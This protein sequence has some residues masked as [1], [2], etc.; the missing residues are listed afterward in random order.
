M[1]GKTVSRRLIHIPAEN[2]G[3]LPNQ[4]SYTALGKPSPQKKAAKEKARSARGLSNGDE[5]LDPSRFW[6]EGLRLEDNNFIPGTEL[7][8]T[9]IPEMMFAVIEAVK[10]GQGTNTVSSR[11]KVG[12]VE[13]RVPII[14]INSIDMTKTFRGAEL[15]RVMYYKNKLLV[16]AHTNEM[17]KITAIED[18]KINSMGRKLSM[19]VIGAGGGI[20]CSAMKYGLDA[21]GMN[22][23]LSWMIDI[24]GRYLQNAIDNCD[25]VTDKTMIVH[26]DASHVESNLLTPMN[27]FLISNACTGASTAGRAKN[28]LS[29]PEAHETGGLM[30]LKTIDILERFLPPVV[31][32]ENVVAYNSTASADLLSGKLKSL[33]YKIQVATYGGEMGTLEDRKRSIMLATHQDVDMDLRTLVAIME[34]EA[35]IK[36]VLDDVPLDSDEWNAYDYLVKKNERDIA[37]GKGFRFEG[38]TGEETKCGTLTA[39]RH[40]VR[41]TDVFIAH[42]QNGQPGRVDLFRMPSVTEQARLMKIPK[43]LVAGR[44]KSTAMEIMGQSG[45]FALVSAIGVMVGR[46]L[47]RQF[48]NIPFDLADQVNLSET[49]YEFVSYDEPTSFEDE[50][51]KFEAE[52]TKVGQTISMF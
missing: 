10:E 42:P 17:N 31:I 41:S 5:V 3:I 24:E 40:K 16:Q 7:K 37:D 38:L 15:V 51:S 20:F 39:G 48:N 50:E 8:I 34:K 36:D 29:S 18:L 30:V 44:N 14:D 32:H 13:G 25:A 46:N 9:H 27:I 43:K 52:A 4:I 33:G 19:G 12:A 45:S 6:A 26:G 28:K 47:D 2:M 35:Q 21:V 11:R 49:N 22:L 1:A 23:D